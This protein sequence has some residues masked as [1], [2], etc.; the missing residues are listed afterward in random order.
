VDRC[1]SPSSFQ[2][3][4]IGSVELFG[5]G[6]SCRVGEDALGLGENVLRRPTTVS[7]DAVEIAI[8]AFRT[9]F[10]EGPYLAGNDVF[11]VEHWTDALDH[12]WRVLAVV[13]TEVDDD[14]LVGAWICDE[15]CSE[16]ILVLDD[17]SLESL[18]GE[19]GHEGS[20]S[21]LEDFGNKLVDVGVKIVGCSIGE[22]VR[23]KSI[24]TA[25]GKAFIPDGLA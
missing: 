15:D 9:A 7:Q 18:V 12:H 21:A 25:Q 10:D 1:R 16:D 11:D 24:P 20:L 23:L 14:R 8:V 22:L 4:S 19:P 6:Q 13:V 17:A 5:Q 3:E 2:V